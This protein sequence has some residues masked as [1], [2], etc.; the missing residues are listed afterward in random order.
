[1][2]PLR[3][4]HAIRT[5]PRAHG[6]SIKRIKVNELPQATTTFGVD[7][8]CELD[9]RADTTCA[10]INCRPIFYT[11][12]HCQAYGFHDELTPIN[13]VP[14]ATVAT[15]WSDPNTGESFILIIHEALYFGDSMDH[16][17]VNPNQ[18]RAFGIDVYDNPYDTY[19]MGIQLTDNKRLP[20]RSDG[21][22]IY[23]TTWSPT[24]EEMNTYEHI[25]VTSDLPWDP[26]SLVMPGGDNE[27]D[28]ASNN[29]ARFMHEMKSNERHH[30]RYES[31]CVAISIDGNTEQLLYERMIQSVR[32]TAERHINELH[33]S[34]RHSTYT[35]EHVAKIFGVGIA[36]AQDIITKTTQKG[37]RH[38]VMPLNRRYR[39]DHIHLNLQYLAGTWTM[40][41]LESKYQSIRQHTGAIIITNGNLV[42]VYP[43]KTKND[44]DCTESLRRMSNEV[45]IPANLKSDMAAAFV[46]HN[47]DFQ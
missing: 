34:T 14:I 18:L 45:G 15:A 42:M 47:T 24:D 37:I 12:Q 7:A 40:D 30:H 8:R 33:S 16:S 35:T 38:S 43:T 11:G 6:R 46:G 13:D 36:T 44:D 2:L 3:E 29:Y 5:G 23:F 9:T 32:V 19:P 26:H 20:F 27:D 39:I 31:D 21:S 28:T 25:V 1:L 4:I 17:L 10:G 41:H 22:T